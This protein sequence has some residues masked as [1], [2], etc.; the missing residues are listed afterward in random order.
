[1]TPSYPLPTY[2]GTLHKKGDR[3][4][5]AYK[6]KIITGTVFHAGIVRWAG[7]CDQRVDDDDGKRWI[8]EDWRLMDIVQ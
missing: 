4:A 2:S 5:W 8:L 7:G 1:M 6:G 3:V